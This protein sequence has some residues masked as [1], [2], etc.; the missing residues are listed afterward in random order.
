MRSRRR[1]HPHPCRL[2]RTFGSFFKHYSCFRRVPIFPISPPWLVF[3]GIGFH[4]SFL[5]GYCPHSFALEGSSGTSSCSC[6]C[7]SSGSVWERDKEEAFCAVLA[8][9]L[10][11]ATQSIAD[12]YSTREKVARTIK[13]LFVHVNTILF[14]TPEECHTRDSVSMSDALLSNTLELNNY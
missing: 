2:A 5:L 14:S 10:L 1:T 3:H 9:L 4:Q 7:T 13:M 8:L 12:R 6:S 11:P